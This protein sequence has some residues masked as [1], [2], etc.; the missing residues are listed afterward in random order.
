MSAYE[1]FAQVYDLFMKDVPYD[2]WINYLEEIFDRFQVSPKLIAELGCGTGNITTRLAQKGFE[3][4]GI[5]L[6]EDMLSIARDKAQKEKLNILYLL[7][8]MRAFELYGTVDCIISLF[9]SMN[10]I[11]EEQELLQTFQWVNNYLN[12]KGLFVFD[13]NTVYKFEEVLDN[14]TFVEHLE[15]ASYVWENTYDPEDETNEFY[16]NFFIKDAQSGLYQRYE[17]YHYEKAYTVACITRLLSEAGLNLVGVYD[18]HTFDAI[19]PDSERIFFVA[20]EMKKKEEG[21]N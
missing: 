19:K 4:I 11:L 14:N 8:D 2:Q 13:M 12:P 15:E 21:N 7:Q 3:M 5:D 10:Y 9:D 16:M 17:E 18:G 20:Q 1:S 6:S